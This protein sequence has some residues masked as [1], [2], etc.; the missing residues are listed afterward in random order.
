MVV[1]MPLWCLLNRSLRSHETDGGQ[2]FHAGAQAVP[3]IDGTLVQRTITTARRELV[4]MVRRGGGSGH[5]DYTA[6]CVLCH[7]SRCRSTMLVPLLLR[8]MVM[9]VMMMLQLVVIVAGMF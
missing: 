7:M 6:G 8:M 4:Q 9:V 3:G 2:L 1:M 5:S